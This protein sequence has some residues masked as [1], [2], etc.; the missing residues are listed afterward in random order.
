MLTMSSVKYFCVLVLKH[1]YASILLIDF[2]EQW[3]NATAEDHFGR[4]RYFLKLLIMKEIQRYCENELKVQ[5]KFS[6]SVDDKIVY[7]V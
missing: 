4:C 1:F 3:L 2:V 7:R 5:F 6:I